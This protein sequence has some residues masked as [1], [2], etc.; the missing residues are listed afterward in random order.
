M[1]ENTTL[2]T[3][4]ASNL[5]DYLK[6]AEG[7]A[8]FNKLVSVFEDGVCYYPYWIKHANNNDVS[9]V[10]IMEFAI[11]RN[12]IYD[13]TVTK[14]GRWGL[15]GSEVT[16][17]PVDPESPTFYFNVNVNVLNWKERKNDNIVL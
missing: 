4:G 6:S 11:V 16:D 2:E 9:S 13:L 12:N 8:I 10:G 17:P 3:L 14:V 5:P 1:E 7:A 15:P